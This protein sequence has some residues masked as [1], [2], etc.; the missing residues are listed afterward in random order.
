MQERLLINITSKN[1][2]A[3]YL[4]NDTAVLLAV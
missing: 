1:Y 3:Y 4:Y 2:I